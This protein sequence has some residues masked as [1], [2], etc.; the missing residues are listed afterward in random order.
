M[1]GY[2]VV[3][4]EAG[5]G[6]RH[7]LAVGPGRR[8]VG[9]RV[10]SGLADAREAPFPVEE[11]EHAFGL[12]E[13]LCGGAVHEEQ[14]VVGDGDGRAAGGAGGPLVAAPRVEELEA[15]WSFGV[16]GIAPEA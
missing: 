15:Q 8:A 13:G 11:Q 6:H 3:A 2:L 1:V 7:L 4:H 10:V 12:A 14:A 16:E 5:G 9:A